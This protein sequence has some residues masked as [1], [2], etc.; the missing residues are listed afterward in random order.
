M[1]IQGWDHP[2]V[3]LLTLYLYRAFLLDT[4][5]SPRSSIAADAAYI[6]VKFV[7]RDTQRV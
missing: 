3:V 7:T 1:K 6:Q 4:C 2:R 5:I